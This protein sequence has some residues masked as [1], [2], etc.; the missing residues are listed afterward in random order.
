MIIAFPGVPPVI[1]PVVNMILA[2][3]GALLLHEPPAVASV[4]VLL[5]PEHTFNDPMI[6]AG[7]GLTVTTSVVIQPVG[8]V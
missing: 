4:S 6:V 7:K 5:R 3:P 1:T 8:N 2:V